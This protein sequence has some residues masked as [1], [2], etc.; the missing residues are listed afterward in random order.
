MK[1]IVIEV[2]NKDAI[3]LRDDG[4][5]VTTNRRDYTIGD[6]IMINTSPIKKRTF[7]M[8]A[9]AAVF[10]LLLSAGVFAYM[11]PYYYVSVDVN[12][13]VVMKAN[14]FER[15]IGMEAKIGRAHV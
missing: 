6:V 7:A 15:V 8:A 3:L 5:F 10:V 2:N 4:Q 11:T 14:R 12:P 13:S 1:S 9:A